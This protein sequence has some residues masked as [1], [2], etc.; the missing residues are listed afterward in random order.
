[1]NKIVTGNIL[2]DSTKLEPCDHQ[3]VETRMFVHI[4]IAGMHGYQI[5]LLTAVDTDI[6]VISIAM[7]TKLNIEFGSGCHRYWLPTHEQ[8]MALGKE[9]CDSLLV[10]CYVLTGSDTVSS[11]CRRGQKNPAWEVWKSYPESTECF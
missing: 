1:M 2:I 7:F 4:S 6:A 10:C 9:T 11:F 8:G 3:E 5:I